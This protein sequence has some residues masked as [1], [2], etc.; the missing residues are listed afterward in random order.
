MSELVED[1]DGARGGALLHAD[2]IAISTK[3]AKR[4]SIEE[5]G[6]ARAIY[7]SRG[8]RVAP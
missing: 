4:S 6:L 7:H 1:G 2:R 8:M 3:K 5:D